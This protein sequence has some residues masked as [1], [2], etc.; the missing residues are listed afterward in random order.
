MGSV[1][2][3]L[4]VLACSTLQLSI[5]RENVL[6]LTLCQ[7][8]ASVASASPFIT[9]PNLGNVDVTTGVRFHP[10]FQK[11]LDFYGDAKL[12]L[13]RWACRTMPQVAVLIFE[14]LLLEWRTS[15]FSTHSEYSASHPGIDAGRYGLFIVTCSRPWHRGFNQIQIL[16]RQRQTAILVSTALVGTGITSEPTSRNQS[17]GTSLCM[18]IASTVLGPDAILWLDCDCCPAFLVAQLPGYPINRTGPKSRKNDNWIWAGTLRRLRQNFGENG[19]TADPSR[20]SCG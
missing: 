5:Q 20:R 8:P 2:G 4:C 13:N 17:A 10:V 12:L 7:L 16:G 3:I 19:L 9:M 15:L 14:I 1:H 6:F 11:I 18:T